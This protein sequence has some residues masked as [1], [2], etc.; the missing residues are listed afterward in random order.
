MNAL[1]VLNIVCAAVVLS[2]SILRVHALCWTENPLAM[3]SHIVIA[4][5][6][7]C[8]I[9]GPSYGY[10]TPQLGEVILNAGLAANCVANWRLTTCC[11][12]PSGRPVYKL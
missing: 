1:L 5:G 12:V 9:C 6:A 4:V 2:Y 11:A 8:V 7:A 3:A 10:M